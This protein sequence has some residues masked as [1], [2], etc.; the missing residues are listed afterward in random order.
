[1][2]QIISYFTLITLIISVNSVCGQDTIVPGYTTVQVLV[3]DF[4]NN[5]RKGEL[6]IFE[7]LNTQN[8]YQ[9]ISNA[10]GKFEIQLK[11]NETYLIKIQSIGKA[12]E[13]SKFT[14]PDLNEGEYFAPMQVTIQFEPPRTYTLE[15]VHFESGKSTLLKSSFEELEN[16]LKF[17]NLKK[18]IIIEIGGHT[19]N[20]GD[21][22]SNLKLSEARAETV[23][24][25][26]VSKGISPNRIVS[27]GYGENHPI[28]TNSTP[29][30]RQNNRRTEVRI[31][32]EK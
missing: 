18:D 19:D 6:I 9:G 22:E 25:Y 4:N 11:I 13:Y 32:D 10:E 30:G 27:K 31:L 24:N 14:I 12:E 21:D 3:T 23:K 28:D 1:M 7:G 2:G 29:E 20:I 16:L 15:N 26:L 5:S 8:T 17:M